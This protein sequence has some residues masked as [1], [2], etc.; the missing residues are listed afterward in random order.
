MY[1]TFNDK[2]QYVFNKHKIKCYNIM[3]ISIKYDK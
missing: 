2:K 1:H 3:G